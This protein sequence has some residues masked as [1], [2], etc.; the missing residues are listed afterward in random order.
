MVFSSPVRDILTET[1]SFSVTIQT[2]HRTTTHLFRKGW[3]VTAPAPQLY[4]KK[5]DSNYKGIE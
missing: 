4:H 2:H 3:A 5:Y 1:Y